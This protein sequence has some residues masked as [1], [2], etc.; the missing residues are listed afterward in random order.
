MRRLGQLINRHP[1]A[2]WVLADQSVVSGSNFVTGIL[3]ARF[4]GPQSFGIFVVLQAVLLYF[5]SF[6]NALI[7]QPMMSAAPQLTEVQRIN[8]LQ[9]VFALQLVLS[10]GLSFIVGVIAFAPYVFDL[11]IKFGIDINFAVSLIAFF[12]AFQL[13]DWQRRYYFVQERGGAAFLIDIISYGG[14]VILLGV[15]YFSHVLDVAVAFWIMAITSFAAFAVGF[16]RDSLQPVFAHA[17]SVLRAGW[18]TGRDYLV[19]WQLQWLGA[20]GILMFSAGV[21]GVEAVGSIRAAQNVVG[22]INILFLAMENVVPVVAAKRYG[23]RGTSGLLHYLGRITTFGS[24]LLIPVLLTLA[25]FAAPITHLLYG[26]EY[27][28]SASL[29]IWQAASIF[30]QFYLR[31]IFFFLRTVA[32]TG[33]IIRAGAIMSVTAVLVAMFTAKQYHEI[34]V[35]AALLAGTAAGLIYSFAAALKIVRTA[36]SRPG[37]VPDPPNMMGMEIKS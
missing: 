16:I 28:S 2:K 4:L 15:A 22:P 7:F 27:A 36:Q 5:N 29:V 1:H 3:L 26:D 11:H 20:Q 37:V 6:Q 17:R 24:A 12:I 13:Q 8:Y 9:G 25:I 18:R 23:Q 30:L 35:M 32:A 34:G 10:I 31:Q 33:A 14:Q 21:V 19:A